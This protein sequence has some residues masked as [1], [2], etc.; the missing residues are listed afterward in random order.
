MTAPRA[1]RA[2]RSA[3]PLIST[4]GHSKWYG[5]REQNGTGGKVGGQQ[6]GAS[7]WLAPAAQ[8]P[9]HGIL[10]HSLNTAYNN[11]FEGVVI[12]HTTAPVE[13]QNADSLSIARA[14]CAALQPRIISPPTDQSAPETSK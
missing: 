10:R 4:V 5:L 3:G 9:Q 2:A 13:L 11:D 14:R 1:E 6:F 7:E 12:T 8:P